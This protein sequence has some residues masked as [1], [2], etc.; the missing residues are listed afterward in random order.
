VADKLDV[1]E[2]PIVS[3]AYHRT[4][5]ECLP[6]FW[7]KTFEIE[8]QYKKS[9]FDL[10]I[11]SILHSS[12]Q[13]QLIVI[14]SINQILEKSST[15]NSS[16]IFPLLEPIIN[17]GPR[18]KSS[19]LKREILR[20]VKILFTNSRYSKCFDDNIDCRQLLQFNID[21]M[22]LDTRSNEISEQAKELK[23]QN[24][25]LFLK[26]KQNDEQQLSTKNFD[27]NDLF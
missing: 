23:K 26:L 20:F 18:T 1:D 7:P 22:I 14:Q 19:G 27:T 3:D 9:T 12:W 24:E 13:I 25:H 2:D 8:I 4:L 5:I 16:D 15:L 6:R 11:E 17:L 21:E 10:L